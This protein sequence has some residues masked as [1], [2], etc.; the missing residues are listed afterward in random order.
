[1]S[2]ISNI[3]RLGITTSS[4][5]A[6]VKADILRAR[7]AWRERS[8]GRD[9]IYDYL[10]VAFDIGKRWKRDGA[11]INNSIIVRQHCNRP[12]EAKSDMTRFPVIIWATATLP[13]TDKGKT[14]S[15]WSRLLQLAE[16]LDANS[17]KK[18]VH[19]NGG[20]INECLAQLK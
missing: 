7:K 8:H 18:F 13:A 12:N 4:R 9:G 17:I 15:K 3:R 19:E 2:S 10:Q 5:E 6:T 16:E 14:R 20:S 11:G 1:M